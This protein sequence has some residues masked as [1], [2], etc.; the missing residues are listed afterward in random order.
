MRRCS[1]GVRARRLHVVVQ[2]ERCKRLRQRICHQRICICR[3]RIGQLGADGRALGVLDDVVVELLRGVDPGRV[4]VGGRKLVVLDIDVSVMAEPCS[5]HK[6]GVGWTY[7][8]E[9]GYARALSA[10][11]GNNAFLK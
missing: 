11:V 5:K 8:G 7:K 2:L 3:Q 10:H 4:E 1:G 9:N 6:E